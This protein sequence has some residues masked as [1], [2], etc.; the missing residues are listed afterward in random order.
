MK[1]HL[2]LIGIDGLRVDRAFD[3]GLAPTLDLMVARG[4]YQPGWVEG[5]TLSGPSWATLLTAT[6]CAQHG[7]IDN[8][9]HEHRIE[10]DSDLLSRAWQQDPATK[11]LSVTSWAPLAHPDNLG[12]IIAPRPDQ[13]AAGLHRVALVGAETPHPEGV[14]AAA[15]DCAI[16]AIMGEGSGNTSGDGSADR[17]SA[18]EAFAPDVTF[19][20]FGE[21]DT[22]GHNFA[23][24]CPEYDDAVQAV[25]RHVALVLAAVER[26]T[27]ATDEEW[28]VAVTTDHG[29]TDEGDHGGD[30]ELERR[31]FFLVDVIGPGHGAANGTPIE[32]P[33][34]LRPI[35]LAPFL[36]AAR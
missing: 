14:D 27:A 28:I 35:E 16:E 34:G 5:P 19:L 9:F 3:T 36:L 22:T 30:S 18:D 25:D 23:G 1:R 17:G 31:T 32:L 4:S 12:P 8:L 15:R 10:P 13:V 7:V 24:L 26:R 6:S 2:V 29:H 33:A 20:Y 21:V 11:T